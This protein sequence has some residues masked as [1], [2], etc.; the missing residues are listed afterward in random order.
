MLGNNMRLLKNILG[1][2]K[3]WH[4]WWLVRNV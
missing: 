4:Q 3:I 2:V 1:K